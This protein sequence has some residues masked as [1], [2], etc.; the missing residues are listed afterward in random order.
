VN[1]QIQKAEIGNTEDIRTVQ[2]KDKDK[3]E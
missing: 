1:E 3:K 2:K